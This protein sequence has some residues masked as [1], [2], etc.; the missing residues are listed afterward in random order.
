M[1]YIERQVLETMNEFKRQGA[2]R[3]RSEEVKKICRFANWTFEN[4]TGVKSIEN[5]GVKH[6]ED[7]LSHLF[8]EGKSERTIYK[9]LLSLNKFWMYSNKKGDLSAVKRHLETLAYEKHQISY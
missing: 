1:R 9:Y 6:Y 5:I 2:K 8:N 7:Y 4:Y 3:A